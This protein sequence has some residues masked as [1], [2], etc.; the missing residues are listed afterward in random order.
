MTGE[1]NLLGEDTALVKIP[2]YK[3]VEE[4]W[5]IQTHLL[6]MHENP[7]ML[8][9]NFTLADENEWKVLNNL[10]FRQVLNYPMN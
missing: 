3:E 10:K 6:D 7:T 1:I 5:L 4:K 9:F 8:F 2:L